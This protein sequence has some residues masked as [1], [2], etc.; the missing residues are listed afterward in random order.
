M[1]SSDISQSLNTTSN[2]FLEKLWKTH[3]PKQCNPLGATCAWEY[4]NEF[5]AE[6]S[7]S[8]HCDSKIPSYYDICWPSRTHYRDGADIKKCSIKN[9]VCSGWFD[10][11]PNRKNLEIPAE[12]LKY[13]NKW[14]SGESFTLIEKLKSHTKNQFG[15][16]MAAWK[17]L[18]LKSAANTFNLI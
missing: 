17:L 12:I 15:G 5:E 18:P 1:V 9:N 8:A 14:T 6:R 4:K 7:S 13:I 3:K 11:L 16:Y 2:I 10:Q